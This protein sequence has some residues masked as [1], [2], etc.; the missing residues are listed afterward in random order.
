MPWEEV[1]VRAL[2]VSQN[3]KEVGVQRAGSTIL[4]APV[5]C[6]G[7]KSVIFIISLMGLCVLKIKW[8]SPL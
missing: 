5:K 8:L 4:P 6:S 7:K 2:R 3:L 1:Y